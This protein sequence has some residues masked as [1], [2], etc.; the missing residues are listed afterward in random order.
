MVLIPVGVLAFSYTKIY[1]ELRRLVLVNEESVSQPINAH[2]FDNLKTFFKFLFQAETS[3]ALGPDIELTQNFI[4]LQSFDN[5]PKGFLQKKAITT[6]PTRRKAINRQ[7]DPP[8]ERI[9]DFNEG[10]AQNKTENSF[11]QFETWQKKYCQIAKDNENNLYSLVIIIF[12]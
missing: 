4:P 8:I 2:R 10:F 3:T 7:K 12:P 9:L 5:N 1:L 6:E 11:P